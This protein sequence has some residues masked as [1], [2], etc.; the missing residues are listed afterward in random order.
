M[1]QKGLRIVGLAGLASFMLIIIATFVAP[2][3]WDAPTT[4]ASA[5][6][7]ADFVFPYRGRILA[8]FF[9]FGIAMGSF[10]CFA[11]GLWSWLRQSEPEPRPLSASFA[12]GAV[13]L[14]ALILAAFVPGA[15]SVYRPPDP[16]TAGLLFD[17]TFGLLALSGIP[18]AVCL[19][20][21]AALV[22]RGAPLARWTAWLAIVG[23]AAHVV[24]TGSFFPR[25]G[26]FSLEGDVIVW[27]P[28]TFFA[29]IL[30]TSVALLR[31]PT[32]RD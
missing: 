5:D 22:F 28:A 14:V 21:Y 26:F 24:I 18:T 3:L 25:T 32:S 11:A 23:A 31:A 19:G 13:V 7:V 16:D 1:T 6:E 12:F 9:L 30:A 20:A 17:M 29:W 4:T 15:L 10:L 8:S 2:P 27:V